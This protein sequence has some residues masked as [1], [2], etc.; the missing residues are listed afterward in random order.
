[1]DDVWCHL[2]V[3]A[4]DELFIP[5]FLQMMLRKLHKLGA[6][7][8]TQLKH[9]KRDAYVT[10]M[11]FNSNQFDDFFL[12]FGLAFKPKSTS[13][14]SLGMHSS[15]AFLNK[16]DNWIRGSISPLDV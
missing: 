1:M 12:F 4:G 3:E 11:I 10:M 5:P 6:P 2:A 7:K 13:W 16:C 15:T 14:G 9:I 8:D